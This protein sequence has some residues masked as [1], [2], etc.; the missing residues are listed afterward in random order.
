M[1]ANALA[2]GDTGTPQDSA[3]Q[4]L[5]RFPRHLNWI[6]A[7]GGDGSGLGMKE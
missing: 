6:W 2:A 5:Q 3:G 4:K 7:I 1:R